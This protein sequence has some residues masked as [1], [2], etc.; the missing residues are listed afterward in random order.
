[1]PC[2]INT[3]TRYRT[4]Y[5]WNYNINLIHVAHCWFLL[6]HIER[7][8]A[9]QLLWL[10][11]IC[12]RSVLHIFGWWREQASNRVWEIY[13]MK[14]KRLFCQCSHINKE[15]NNGV[16][17]LFQFGDGGMFFSGCS[18]LLSFL[19][20]ADSLLIGWKWPPECRCGCSSLSCIDKL[21]IIYTLNGDLFVLPHLYYSLTVDDT[22]S[23]HLVEN[24]TYNHDNNSSPQQ[25]WQYGMLLG[26]SDWW[27]THNTNVNLILLHEWPNVLCCSPHQQPGKR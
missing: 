22:T 6:G 14:E 9:S 26:L 2:S 18:R 5:Q 11:S 8:G 7:F 27:T 3:Q 24:K 15:V 25:P 16:G 4:S 20:W 23:A 1:M 12:C 19:L 17:Y 10:C 13:F 21:I